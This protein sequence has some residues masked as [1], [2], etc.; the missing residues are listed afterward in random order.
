[1]TTTSIAVTLVSAVRL[2]PGC[3]HAHRALHDDAVGAATAMG[4]LLRAELIAAI[5]GVQDET[6]AVLTFADRPA[7]DEWLVAPTRLHAL[8][9]MADLVASDRKVT[10]VGDFGGWF[11]TAPKRWKQALA[12]LVGLIPVAALAGW[13]RH[14]L[15]PHSPFLVGVALVSTVNVAALTWFVMPVLTRALNPWLSR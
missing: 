1:M 6:V 5:P 3:E 2:R 11:A 12:V 10:V 7:L 14:Q 13:G 4:G 8:D 9:A 15:L